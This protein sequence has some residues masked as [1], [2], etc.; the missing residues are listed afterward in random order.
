[1]TAAPNLTE[2]QVDELRDLGVELEC[3]KCW[4]KREPHEDG[5]IEHAFAPVEPDEALYVIRQAYIDAVAKAWQ[6]LAR[7]KLSNFGYWSS[8]VVFLGQML[9]E[10]GAAQPA[11]P[12][13][14]LVHLARAKTKAP[15]G[16]WLAISE[17]DE[18]PR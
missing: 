9:R 3:L 7:Y 17:D 11:N 4:S 14:E 2:T 5:S 10:C 18:A 13:R 16:A 15:A 1:M 6:N 8:R 12:F